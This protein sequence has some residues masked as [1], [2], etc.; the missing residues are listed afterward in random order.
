M[1]VLIAV[2]HFLPRHHGGAEWRAFRTASELQRR[3]TQ[4]QLLTVES[5]SNE[6]ESELG[7]EDTEY[8]GLPVRRLF[9][10][11]KSSSDPFRWSYR[12]PVVERQTQR[13]LREFQP[14]VMHLIGGYLLSGTAIEAAHEAG[15][16]VVLT[17]TDFWFMCLREE[18]RRYRW[19]AMYTLG[20]WRWGDTMIRRAGRRLQLTESSR[21]DALMKE[22][23]RYLRQA[24]GQAAAVISPSRFLKNLMKERGYCPQPFHYIRQGLETNRWAPAEWRPEA[25][26]LRIGYIGQLAPHKGVRL[27][28]EAF[29]RLQ[30]GARRPE[31][32]IYGDMERH[33]QFVRRLRSETEGRADITFAGTFSNQ[34][35]RAIH[36]GLDVLVVPSTWYENSP[37]VILEAFASRTP[38]IVSDLGGMAELVRHNVNGLLFEPGDVASLAQRLQ[39]VLD[40]D[41]LLPRL[42]QGIGPVKAVEDETD[43]LDAIYRTVQ[44]QP[45][46]AVA[47]QEEG[48]VIALPAGVPA[49]ARTGQGTESR[50]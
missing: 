42:R 4:V 44:G 7:F 23:R 21:M 19:P 41:A 46:D 24:L 29:E 31:L 3:G 49:V 34:Q 17:L 39:R 14:D 27:L 6:G 26:R 28:V 50:S 43:E 48:T 11:L 13:L 2:H 5:I 37:T 33:P 9:Y 20:L 8:E 40:D 15:V 36:A 16:P 35:V 10:D 18:Q 1:K 25:G 38:A 32:I 30:A 47:R 12:N 22:R 45:L